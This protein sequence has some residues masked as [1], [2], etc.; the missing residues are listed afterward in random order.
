MAYLV[1]EKYLFTGDTCK[2]ADG[3]AY[4]GTHYTM[5]LDMQNR[6]IQ[7]LAALNNIRCVFTAHSGWT[8]DFETAFGCWRE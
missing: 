3:K 6:S 4:A 8:D 2:F 7:K 5:D 1:D